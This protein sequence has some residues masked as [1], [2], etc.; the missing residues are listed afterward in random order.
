MFTEKN[1]AVALKLM[2]FDEISKGVYQKKFAENIS[3][4]ADFNAKKLFYPAQVKNRDRDNIIDSA[5]KE[6]FVV[7]ECVNRLLDK[8]YKPEDITLEKAWHL[9]H[10]T[11]SGRADICVAHDG[12]TLFIIECKTFGTEFNRELENLK[13]DGG[14]LFSYWQQEQSCKWLVLYAST[15]DNEKIIFNSKS[16]GC[17]EEIYKN[18]HT[19][20]ERFKIWSDIYQKQLA[21]D[22]IFHEDTVAYQIGVKPFRKKDLT[23]FHNTSTVN[24]FEEILRHNNVSNKERAFDVLLALFICKLVDE[25]HKNFDD[26]VDFQFKFG[27]DDYFTFQDRLQNLYQKGMAEFMR[28]TITYIP[29]SAIEELFFQNQ[30]ENREVLINSVKEKFRAQKFFTNNDFAFIHVHNEELFYKNSKIL[31]EVVNIFKNYK[32]I[33]ATDLQTLGDLFEQLLDKGFKQ[34]E[35]QFFTPIPITRFIWDS[36]PLEKIISGE[37]NFTPPKIIDYACGAGHFLTQGFEAVNDFFERENITAPEFWEDEKI[38]GVEKDD[39]LALVSKISFF[40]HGADKGKIKFGDGLENYSTEGISPGTFDILVSNPP[41]SVKDFK[42]Y[43]KLENEFETLEKISNNGSEIETLFVERISQL[44]KPGGIAAVILP[45]SI[46]NKDGK[47]FVSARENILQNFYIRAIAEFGSKTFSA[48]GTKTNILFMEK[49]DNPPEKFKLFADS[50]SEIFSDK[51]SGSWDNEKIFIAWTTKIKVDP[52]AYKKF[53][54]RET[55]YTDWKNISHFAEYV[56]AF[57]KSGEYK[58]KIRQSTFKLLPDDEKNSALN[59]MFYEFAQKVEREKIQYF[60]QTCTQNT[61]I[62]SAPDNNDEQEKFL[63]YT[64]SNRKGDEGIKEKNPGGLMYDKENRRAENKLAAAVRKSFYDE[65]IEIPDAQK[66]FYRLNL[67]DMIDFDGVTFTKVIKLVN[68]T[69]KPV[70]YGGIFKAVKLENAAPYVTEKISLDEIEISN[71]IT[72]DNMLKNKQ[73]IKIFEGEPHISSITKFL[74]KDILVSNIRPYLKKIWFANRSGGCSNDVLVFRSFNAE[75]LLPEYLFV[76]LSQD[77]FFDF[78]MSTVKGLKMPRGDKKNILTFEFPFPP[79]DEQKKIVGEFNSIDEKISEQEK[80]ISDGD[81]KIKNKF[82]EMFLNKNFP[83]ENLGD[84]IVQIRGVSY[85]PEDLR[86]NL[87]ADSLILLRANNIRDGK[88]NHDEVQ[89]VSKEKVSDEQI[90]RPGDI[91]ISAS[92]GSL[93]HVGKSAMC[94]EKNSGET[95]GAF[96]KI[97]RTTG[98]LSAKYVSIYF[99]TNE[100]RKI[101]MQLANGANINNLKNEHIADLKIPVPPKELQEEFAAYV[102]SVES[103]KNSALEQKNLLQAERD[104]LVKKYFR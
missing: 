51:I 44:L 74:S 101:I 31:Q 78:M 48:T 90:I 62:I 22:V 32:I 95:F 88:I 28:E 60:A 70:K 77:Y 37:K 4:K 27:T 42:Q 6:N 47:S 36:L 10:E 1:F 33:G 94:T 76:V 65:Q 87:N 86:S 26:E 91:L 69:F 43:L 17:N 21:D 97:I 98:D 81:T 102:E 64:W 11:K 39:R 82:D 93:E 92:S 73:G 68:P 84:Y 35:G 7:F 79:I 57:E 104:E 83:R 49:I 5:H 45:S 103:E 19:V 66:Y 38:F 80:I 3:M 54:R 59:Q 23:E 41:Y 12:K 61:L 29:F 24:K 2:N 20:P 100:Y 15:L 55:N 71:Y 58:N 53:I 30:G 40:M 85:K 50:V 52:D 99:L 25:A 96:C 67:A 72:T 8:G 13:S 9:G 56:T 14:Q 34:N 63:G 18:A 75:K 16:V 46:L 89:F